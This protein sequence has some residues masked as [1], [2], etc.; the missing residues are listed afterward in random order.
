MNA[1]RLTRELAGRPVHFYESVDSTNAAARAWLQSNSPPPP[2]AVVVADEQTAGRGR[3]G[4]RWETPP[5]TAIAMSLVVGAESPAG[6]PQA[7]G[8]ATAAAIQPLVEGAV[9]LKW[10]NDVEIDGRKVAGILIEHQTVAEKT[11]YIVGI[12]INVDLNFAAIGGAAEE[13]LRRATSISRHTPN[14]EGIDREVLVGAVAREFDRW[15]L[16][17]G[18]QQRWTALLTTL[19]RR[20]SVRSRGGVIT[21]RA[22]GVDMYGALI[23]EDEQG[24]TVKVGA[25]D[26]TVVESGFS[27]SV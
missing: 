12:G 17:Q 11:F 15:R 13:L 5:G 26:V 22:T 20:I 24:E 9:G 7:S 18:L 2:G 16:D 1:E 14:A 6:L 21:G 25:G 23:L 10:P 4:R 8:V 27:N 3:F 19:E